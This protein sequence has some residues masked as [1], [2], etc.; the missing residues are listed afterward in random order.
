MDYCT[1]SPPQSHS[2]QPRFRFTFPALKMPAGTYRVSQRNIDLP[3]L[4]VRDANWSHSAFVMYDPT[5]SIQPVT[6][7][8][9]TFHQYGDTDYFRG[10]LLAG[11]EGWHGNNREHSGEKGRDEKGTCVNEERRSSIR[12]SQVLTHGPIFPIDCSENARWIRNGQ[13]GVCCL[14]YTRAG[15]SRGDHLSPQ[16]WLCR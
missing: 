6:Q 2:L 5:L 14:N 9:A 12:C 13:A 4:L 8:K 3:L 15:D 11:E 10:L 1:R 7:R 16:T